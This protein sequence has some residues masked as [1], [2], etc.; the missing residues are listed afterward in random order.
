M[1]TLFIIVPLS[2]VLVLNLP[3]MRIGVMKRFAQ[4]LVALYL[5]LQTAAAVA[6]LAGVL[7]VMGRFLSA[8]LDLAI[9][10]DALGMLVV[11]LVGLVSLASLMTA[12]GTMPDIDER[13]YFMNLL[14]VAVTG[15]NGITMLA[16][17]FSLYVFLEVTAVSSFIMIAAH[18]DAA[19]L[20]GSFKYLLLSAIATAALLSGIALLLLVAPD[21]SFTAVR[22]ALESS[23]MGFYLKLGIVLFIF[24]LAI[25]S[26]LVPF[27]WWLPDAYASAPAPVSVLLAG[28][29]TK[30]SG[31]Y[32]LIRICTTVFPYDDTMK[33]ML[34]VLGTISVLAGALAALDQRDLK[35]MLA[36]SSV[37]Q[38]GYIILGLGTGTALGIAGALFHFMNHALFK[39]L[40]FVNASALELRL[41]TRDMTRMG[42]LQ[43]RMPV[44]G[45]TSL[46]AF[47]SAAGIPPMA[48]FW[49]KLVIII[50]L[51]QTGLQAAAVVAALA[52][53]LTM[54]Y[55][56]KIQRQVF[57]G[58]LRENLAAVT[59]A[60]PTL[61]IPALVLAALTAG[62][63]LAIGPFFNT[64]MLPLGSLLVR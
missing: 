43:S 26:G 19:G 64:I 61:V 36:Y 34:V 13:H 10:L 53:L 11:G 2:L 42:G 18:K 4:V 17:L 16:D 22:A 5:V 20:E 44:T 7:P 39:S 14:L 46:I 62:L 23:Q 48:G 9:A 41:D 59:E 29:V 24:G 21:S 60:G 56:L 37:S 47:M 51:W 49:S 8:F 31:V 28:I 52:S 50:A 54:A 35:R 45:A 3:F 27:H 38:V 15:L 12:F 58:T 6:G 57:F 30:V 40:L 63:G 32:A 33:T 1:A 25:K 55:F